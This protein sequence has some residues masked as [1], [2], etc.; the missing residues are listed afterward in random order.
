MELLMDQ[1]ILQEELEEVELG[2]KVYQVVEQVL[3]EQLILEEVE[4][5]VE[6]QEDQAEPAVQESLS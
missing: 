2:E 3:Q 4:A 1:L 5:E 6:V